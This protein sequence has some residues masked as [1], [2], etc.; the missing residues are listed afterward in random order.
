MS[1]NERLILLITKAGAIVGSE[2]KLAKEL[3]IPQSHLSMWKSGTKTC[4]ASDRARLAGFAREDAVQELVRATI[5]AAKGTKRE[6]LQRV[7]G[8]L[9]LQ[10]GAAVHSAVLTV[11]SLTFGLAMTDVPRCIKSN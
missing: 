6:Q 11:A 9:S 1:T 7:L 4:T 10:T 5:E 3:G 2:Y 8:K